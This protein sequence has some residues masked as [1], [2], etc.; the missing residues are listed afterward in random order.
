MSKIVKNYHKILETIESLN[1][2]CRVK[3]AGRKPKTSDNQFVALSLTAEFMSIDSEY[4][5]FQMIPENGIPNILDRSQFNKRRRKLFAYT[6]LIRTK[7]NQ[8]FI[9]FEDYFVVDSMPLEICKMARHKRTKICKEFFESDR[10]N[11]NSR[12]RFLRI[13]KHMVLLTVRRAI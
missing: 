4:L 6:E 3:K 10:R 9:E 8:S 7:L 5:L 1:I 11:D 13:S 12:K 2:G